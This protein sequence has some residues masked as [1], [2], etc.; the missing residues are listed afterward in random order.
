MDGEIAWRSPDRPD[1]TVRNLSAAG[2]QRLLWCLSGKVHD[3][4]DKM[5][6]AGIPAYGR[7]EPDITVEENHC[8]TDA[9]FHETL[10]A[11]FVR[12]VR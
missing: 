5:R 1:T 2:N 11:S 12:A 4:D 7:L 10:Q 6:K 9:I 3:C 8:L